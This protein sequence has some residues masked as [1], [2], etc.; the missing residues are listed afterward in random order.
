VAFP[1]ETVYGLG[2]DACNE[3]AVQKIFEAKGRPS[4][5]PLIVHVASLEQALAVTDTSQCCDPESAL[6]KLSALAVLWPG[7][8]SIIL[9][10]GKQI[11]PAVTGGGGTIAVRIPRHPVALDLIRSFGGPIAAPSA[12]RS[13][14]VSPT[15]AAHVEE[16]LGDCVALILDGGPCEIGLESTVLSLMHSAPLILR[17][18]AVTQ[19][20]L[21]D[22][23]GCFVESTHLTVASGS[24]TTPPPL[25]SPGLLAK[26]YSPRTPVVLRS[27]INAKTELPTALG[28]ILFSDEP[29]TF[30]ATQ[31]R[32]LSATRE[33]TEVAAALFAALRELD[34]MDLDLIIVDVCEPVGLGEAIMDRLMRAA[35]R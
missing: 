5:N 4:N 26:H 21:S 1:T 19:Q 23:L 34:Q 29:T 7:P 16:G 11:A 3:S 14:Y 25:L 31:R 28:V 17:P 24:T 27:T 30:S 8:L 18:G 35:T 9:P 2:A 10:K 12:N 32:V 15:T 6:K 33:L 20:Q 13:T 22:T